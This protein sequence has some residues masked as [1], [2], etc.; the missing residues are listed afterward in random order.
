MCVA[1]LLPAHITSHRSLK[2]FPPI[3]QDIPT[4]HSSS[5]QISSPISNTAATI[6]AAQ[7]TGPKAAIAAN[8]NAY[9]AGYFLGGAEAKFTQGQVGTIPFKTN[10][11]FTTTKPSSAVVITGTIY[12][13]NDPDITQDTQGMV[14][15]LIDG[16]VVDGYYY[17][18]TKGNQLYDLPI[19]VAINYATTKPAGTYQ[20]SV[21]I[22]SWRNGAVVNHD[23]SNY[24]GYQQG[25]LDAVS[26]LIK[27]TILTLGQ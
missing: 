14:Y 7:V 26:M 6:A 1:F 16:T 15:L 25:T 21:Q 8:S 23:P 18:V 11:S 13:G 22:K 24:S 2:I 19:P 12:V 9:S 4:P 5:Q 3:T 20:V 17:S 10:P 27:L